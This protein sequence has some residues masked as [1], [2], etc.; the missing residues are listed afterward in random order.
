MQQTQIQNQVGLTINKFNSKH[1]FFFDLLLIVGSTTSLKSPGHSPGTTSST[2]G[3]AS[4]GGLTLE[5]FTEIVLAQERMDRT[6]TIV[7]DDVPSTIDDI[8]DKRR[9]I[10]I[11]NR[12]EVGKYT[13]IQTGAK[14]KPVVLTPR[15]VSNVSSH[16][17]QPLVKQ[18][19][20][21]GKMIPFQDRKVR[22]EMRKQLEIVIK[23]NEEILENSNVTHVPRKRTID[24]TR[25][26]TAAIPQVKVET[27]TASIKPSM[28]LNL[29]V[30]KDLMKPK[31]ENDNNVNG[32][33]EKLLARYDT[34][35]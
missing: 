18:G 3:S 10:T 19:R 5:Q 23:K 24:L 29:S 35:S 33:I 22:D 16:V 34:F 13:S 2:S 14:L 30:R 7:P 25:C 21:I 12:H 27:P 20:E 15:H 32:A 17:S 8:V 1:F 28:P 31:T 26:K 4:N 6:E 9:D 11:N